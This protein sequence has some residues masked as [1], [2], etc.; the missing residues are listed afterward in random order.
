MTSAHGKCSGEFPSMFRAARRPGSK[1]NVHGQINGILISHKNYKIMPCAPTQTDLEILILRGVRER[2]IS[3]ATTCLCD[4]DKKM[5]Q[6]NLFIRQKQTHGHGKQTYGYQ[7]GK[8]GG[9]N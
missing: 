1:L 7:K 5:I 9:I 6:M 3:Y 8:G 2:R 4:P